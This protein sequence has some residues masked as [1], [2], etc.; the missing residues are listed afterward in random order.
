MILYQQYNALF[1]VHNLTNRELDIYHKCDAEQLCHPKL[2]HLFVA[3]LSFHA[4]TQKGL[5]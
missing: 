4:H 1:V 5:Q 3:K 2:F